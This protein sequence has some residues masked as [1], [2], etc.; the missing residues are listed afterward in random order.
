MTGNFGVETLQISHQPTA[1]EIAS[2]KCPA[3]GIMAQ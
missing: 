3:S 2:L 1:S